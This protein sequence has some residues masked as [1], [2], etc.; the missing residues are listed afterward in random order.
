MNHQN[1]RFAVSRG[2]DFAPLDVR[3]VAFNRKAALDKFVCFNDF[4]VND[5]SEGLGDR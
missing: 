3:L 4:T 1:T 5:G 2:E